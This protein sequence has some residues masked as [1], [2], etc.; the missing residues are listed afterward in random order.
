MSISAEDVRA[1]ARLAR[2]SIAESEIPVYAG[3][4]S[5]ILDF[6]AQMNAVDTA[7]VAPL[8][9]P[10]ELAARLRPDTVTEADRREELQTGAPETA[11]GLYLVPQV[12]E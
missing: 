1:I 3:Q 10:L 9:H 11:D 12:I 4:L 8:A 7:G 2:L 5:S 6:V